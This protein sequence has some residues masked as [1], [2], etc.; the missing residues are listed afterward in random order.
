LTILFAGDTSILVSNPNTTDF[1]S[2]N[3]IVSEC[4]DEWFDANLL[5]L[6]F[7]KT[8]CRQFTAKSKPVS[9][10]NITYDNKQVIPITNTKFVGIF[11][12]DTL[13]WEKH[14]VCII[15]Q[16]STAC[17]VM[18]SLK[19]YVSHYSLRMVVYSYFHSIM[20]YIIF[21]RNCSNNIRVFMLQKNIFRIILGCESRDSCRY[22]FKELKILHLPS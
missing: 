16:L 1:Q 3:N 8:R 12:N 15:P 21:R 7:S 4:I 5:S 18:R 17:Y 19:S 20:N 9:G 11:I 6:D 14:I 10:V 2:D 13:T 22:L